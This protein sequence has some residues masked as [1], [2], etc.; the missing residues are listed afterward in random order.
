VLLPALALSV[1]G[2]LL[3]AA[4]VTLGRRQA[5]ASAALDGF[6]LGFVPAVLALRML[7]H[8]M[9]SLGARAFALAALAY[10]AL[11][12]VDR[13]AHARDHAASHPFHPAAGAGAGLLVPM[14]AV[15]GM[16]DGA[17]LAVALSSRG[18]GLSLAAALILHRM[19]EGLFIASSMM[20]NAGGRKTALALV[21]LAFS[22]V[23][24]A[25]L[26]QA[27]LDAIPD[28]FFDGALA[29][30]VGA[31]LRLA[32]HSHAPRPPTAQARALSG[33][34]FLG[35]VALVLA[36]PD[37][38]GLF[39]LAIPRELSVQ[40]ALL[41]LFVETAPSM[42]LGVLG[43]GLLRTMTRARPDAWLRGG[44]SAL[45]A[46]RGMVFGVPLQVCSCGVLPVAQRLLR[47]SAP[48][49][50]V[51]AFMLGTPEFDVGGFVL[52]VRL[53][54]LPL[55]LARLVAGAALA[56]GVGIT[57]ATVARSMALRVPTGP[58]RRAGLLSAPAALPSAPPPADRSLAGVLRA[59]LASFDQVAAWYVFGLLLA[60]GFEAAMPPLS[61]A[62]LLGGWDVPLTALLS[63]P[64]YVCAQGATPLAAVM[65]HKGLSPGA[66]LAL[67]LVGPAANLAAWRMLRPALGARVAW[68]FAGA[69][70]VGAI[71]LG[72]LVNRVVSP[73]SLPEIHALASHQHHPWELIAAGTLAL[74]LASSVLRLGPRGWIATMSPSGASSTEH[75]HH[76]HHSH[77]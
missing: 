59:G 12:W 39:R 52:S 38:E 50:A 37:P 63:V 57:A 62:R 14:L 19:P 51:T 10:A 46:L 8:A 40:G 61:L 21:A 35:G 58:V 3:G 72:L 13:R 27:L 33:L 65:V 17:A 74:L 43:A 76:H 66:A 68:T 11:W 25:A 6:S 67:L 75:S 32:M 18:V 53:L 36:L 56:F 23:L 70:V 16:S 42:L 1:L 45:Q 20:P 49:A 7:P 4:L 47:A 64:I 55:A 44:G 22:T 48:I 5:L 15:H 54:G 29:L 34:T 2:L 73:G 77:G 31:M 24:G 69:S 9:G 41:P 71:A 28:E 30:G 26:G 60:V